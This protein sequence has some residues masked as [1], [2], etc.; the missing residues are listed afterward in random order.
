LPP[1]IREAINELGL[2]N[3]ETDKLNFAD[4]GH[5]NHGVIVGE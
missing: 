5:T 2:L 4:T 1:K 3:K